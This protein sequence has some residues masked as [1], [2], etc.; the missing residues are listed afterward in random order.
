MALLVDPV[1]ADST[2]FSTGVLWMAAVAYA[3]QIYCD[4]SGYSDLA[5]GTA[6]LLGYRLAINF[7]LPFSSLNYSELWRRWHI[8]LSSWI[9]DYVFIPLGGSRGS[10]WRTA[11][12]LIVAF[13]LSGL[14]HGSNWN[15][16][17]WGLLNG[18]FLVIHRGFRR[19]CE[20]RPQLDGVL[21]TAGGVSLRIALTFA[22]FT[23]LF[24]VFRHTTLTSAALMLGRM[25]TPHA[26]LGAPTPLVFFWTTV[27]V[28]FLIHVARRWDRPWHWWGLAPA[29]VQGIV[30]ASVAILALILAPPASQAFIYFQF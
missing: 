23:L 16:V 10:E 12:N 26:G 2:A 27:V 22:A 24:V 4:F 18:L 7:N 9:R 20:C 30:Y 14:W 25:F 5:L 29:P 19:W 8:S 11:R 13:T 28:M 1:F 17:L 15:F 3:I 6:H 21:K